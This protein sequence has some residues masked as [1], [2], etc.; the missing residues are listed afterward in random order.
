MLWC[1]QTITEALNHL[2]NQ[3]SPETEQ[4]EQIFGVHLVDKILDNQIGID[5]SDFSE[6][7]KHT[8]GPSDGD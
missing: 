2:P 1:C 6:K 4:L 7:G 3:L 8:D 5:L